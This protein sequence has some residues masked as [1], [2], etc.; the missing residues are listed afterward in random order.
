MQTKLSRFSQNELILVGVNAVTKALERGPLS[1]VMVRI[2]LISFYGQFS[3]S[4]CVTFLKVLYFA[5]NFVKMF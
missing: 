5:W 1:L 2:Y 4:I 3:L